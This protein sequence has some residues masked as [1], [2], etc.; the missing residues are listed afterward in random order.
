MTAKSTA[1]RVA[2]LRQRREDEG[3]VRLELWCHP[4]DVGR[5]K[6]F[7]AA[8]AAHR[9]RLLKQGIVRD[10]EEVINARMLAAAKKAPAKLAKPASRSAR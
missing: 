7:A 4:N 3:L 9:A 5:I 8:E 10:T 2:A 1:E 6:K